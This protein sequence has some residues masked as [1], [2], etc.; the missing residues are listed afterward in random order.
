MSIV[1]EALKKAA[2]EDTLQRHTEKQKLSFST[3]TSV[4]LTFFR[5][6]LLPLLLIIL[7]GY[8]FTQRD[9]LIQWRSPSRSSAKAVKTAP[10]IK[11]SSVQLP[12]VTAR[13]TPPSRTPAGN[14]ERSVEAARRL[15]VGIQLFQNGKFK[16]AEDEFTSALSLQPENAAAHNDLGM[17][18]KAQG[19]MTDA[20]RHYLL[21]LQLNPRYPEAMNNLGLLYDQQGRVQEAIQQYRKAIE[22]FPD[23]PEAHLNYAQ[24]LERAGYPNEARRYYLSFLALGSSSSPSLRLRVQRHLDALP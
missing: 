24:V 23:Y 4:L 20:E 18:L 7:L 11:D 13:S 5:R 9:R 16:E 12:Q 14:A 22:V 3:K 6:T 21:A 2:K 19:Q 1:N 15:N 8:V 17:A 10:V